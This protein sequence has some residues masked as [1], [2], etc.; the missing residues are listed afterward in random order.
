MDVR[1]FLGGSEMQRPQFLRMCGN[2]TISGAAVETPDGK[3]CPCALIT[4][5]KA[6]EQT[7]KPVSFDGPLFS[8]YE[9]AAQRGMELAYGI[10]AAKHG[11]DRVV[12][13]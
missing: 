3:F 7:E 1:L 5:H 2:T 9:E 12:A 4:R 8:T 11:H 6:T 10:H 13:H